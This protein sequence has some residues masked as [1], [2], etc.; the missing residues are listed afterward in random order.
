MLIP[1]YSATVAGLRIKLLPTLLPAP[2]VLYAIPKCTRCIVRRNVIGHVNRDVEVLRN[3]LTRIFC[4][5]QM[6]KKVAWLDDKPTSVN[7]IC[8]RE[9]DTN[10][11]KGLNG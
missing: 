4:A 8:A 9:R 1:R 7:D 11:T 10:A 2:H 5:N 6:K 3:A